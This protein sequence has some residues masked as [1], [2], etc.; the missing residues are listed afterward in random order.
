MHSLTHPFTHTGGALASISGAHFLAVAP[1]A[2][3]VDAILAPSRIIASDLLEFTLPPLP[4]PRR[5]VVS[6]LSPEPPT[7]SP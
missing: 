6:V 4:T 1:V 5:A 3:Y 7:N 2:V